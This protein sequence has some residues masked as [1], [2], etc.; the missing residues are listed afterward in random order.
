MRVVGVDIAQSSFFHC[1][2]QRSFT[3]STANSISPLLEDIVDTLASIKLA[4]ERLYES[5]AGQFPKEE[6]LDDLIKIVN[7]SERIKATEDFGEKIKIFSS[8]YQT[9]SNQVRTKYSDFLP[10]EAVK[11]IEAGEKY[12]EGLKKL[13][14]AQEYIR[15]GFGDKDQ[16]SQAEKIYTGMVKLSEVSEKYIF[17]FPERL[18]DILKNIALEILADSTLQPEQSD[19]SQELIDYL[20]A[21]KNTA[22]GILWQLDN[23]KKGKKHTTGELVYWL[24]T[25]PSWAGNDFEECLEYINRLRK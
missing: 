25:A 19:I 10:S 6:I 20:T 11:K 23:Y 16:V 8:E 5:G 1:P 24:E 2:Q 4:L 21:I 9:F 12:T 7:I 22:R 14:V 13:L 18:I 17:Y 15:Q 3:M